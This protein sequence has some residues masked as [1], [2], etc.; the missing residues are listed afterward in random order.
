MVMNRKPEYSHIGP[1]FIKYASTQSVLER[2]IAGNPLRIGDLDSETRKSFHKY[3]DGN[4]ITGR[5][6]FTN[7]EFVQGSINWQY[8]VTYPDYRGNGVYRGLF[9]SL[10]KLAKERGAAAI[11]ASVS[12]RNPEG[13]N[14]LTKWGFNR[15]GNFEGLISYVHRL[16]PQDKL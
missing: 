10:V 12:T 14:T 8:A 16:K 7:F 4:N 1:V 3:E 9:E 11:Y 5:Y 6:G 2:I 15:C 13:Q